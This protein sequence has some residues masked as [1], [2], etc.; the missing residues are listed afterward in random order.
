MTG[1]ERI[2]P[3]EERNRHLVMALFGERSPA[4]HDDAPIGLVRVVRLCKRLFRDTDVIELESERPYSEKYGLVFAV[5]ANG[6]L[7]TV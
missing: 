6:R 5:P 3:L 4:R 7:S 1:L 2:G